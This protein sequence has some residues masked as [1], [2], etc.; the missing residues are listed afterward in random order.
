VWIGLAAQLTSS[1][2]PALLVGRD[3]NGKSAVVKL[4]AGIETYCDGINAW[5]WLK[6]GAWGDRND[7]SGAVMRRG[8]RPTGLGHFITSRAHGH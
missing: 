4:N 2:D 6:P 7:G 3:N 5:T 1:L 8:F